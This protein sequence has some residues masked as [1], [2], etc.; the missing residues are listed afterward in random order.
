LNAQPSLRLPAW[1]PLALA[2]IVPAA[3]GGIALA[4]HFDGLYGQDSFAYFDFGAGPVRHNLLHLHP[5]PS[6]FW[7]PGYPVALAVVSLVVGRSPLAGQLVSLASGALVAVFT[8]LLVREVWPESRRSPAVPLVAGLLVAFTGQLWQSSAVVMPDT[9]GLALATAGIWALARYGR[10]DALRLLLLAAALLAAATLSRSIN[11]IVAVPCM[12]YALWT[13]VRR[14]RWRALAHVGVAALLATAILAPVLFGD[15]FKGDFEVHQWSFGRIFERTFS[16]SDGRLAYRLPT[17]VYYAIAPGRWAYL[18][19]LF[20]PL[21]LVG[22][23]SV[24]RS[25]RLAP[26]ALLLGWPAAVYAFYAGA[27]YQNFRFT[28]AYLPPL[29]ILAGIGAVEVRGWLGDRRLA[30]LAGAGVLALGLA[31]MAADGVH[32]TRHLIAQKNEGVEIVRWTEARVRPDS[33]LLTFNVT[34]MFRRYGRLET[35][36]L[37]WETPRSLAALTS[38]HRWYLLV[39][40]P[41]VRTQWWERSPGKNLRW[42]RRARGLQPLG[43]RNGFTL[44][45]V[46]RS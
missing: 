33:R 30:V 21:I 16:T 37:F 9:L 10:V 38:S 42:L 2:L 12:G 6:F 17:S 20:A 24:I 1:W 18:T 8:A 31:L 41:S 43:M 26:I 27:A 22:V 5:P 35:V 15:R 29:A 40:L 25:R 3:A 34:S 44:F 39:D 11:G 45:R 4:E 7:A 28:L 32:T 13:A 19:P 36:E 14:H 46:G 23:W